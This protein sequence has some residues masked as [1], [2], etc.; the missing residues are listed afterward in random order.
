[1][2]DAECCDDAG[3]HHG[4]RQ[5]DAETHDQHEPEAQLL[6]L[7]AQEQHRDGSR[8]RDEPARQA[9]HDD[10]PRRHGSARKPPADVVGM[11]AGVGVILVA[12][13]H[14][15]VVVFL[16]REHVDFLVRAVPQL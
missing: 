3:R 11:G 10:L 2:L 5:A 15:I 13:V 1:V 6:E 9:E 4:Q 7:D 8:T 14:V 16:E 12:E